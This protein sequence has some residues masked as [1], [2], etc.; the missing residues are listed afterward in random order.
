MGWAKYYEDNVSICNGRMA[1][2]E[3]IP[4]RHTPVRRYKAVEHKREIQVKPETK[5]MEVKV[6]SAIDQPMRNG[7][8]GIELSFITV[9]EAGICRK[10]QMNGWWWSS[11]QKCWCNCNTKVNRRYAEETARRYQAQIT[12]FEA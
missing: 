9:P 7:R 11:A 2:S 8:R 6:I 5:P 12:I 1:V 3:S 10:L 4:V